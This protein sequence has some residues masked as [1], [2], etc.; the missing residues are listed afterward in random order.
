MY[1]V[2]ILLC[3]NQSD[4]LIVPRDHSRTHIDNL[5][6]RL[7]VFK[8]SEHEYICIIVIAPP[9]PSIYRS[10]YAIAIWCLSISWPKSTLVFFDTRHSKHRSKRSSNS[11]LYNCFR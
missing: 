7:I 2:H 9:P 3:S 4:W 5:E 11:G 6:I 8:V 10:A 1:F